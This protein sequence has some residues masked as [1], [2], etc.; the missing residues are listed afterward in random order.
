MP[1]PAPLLTA[2][3]RSSL[4]DL[5]ARLR[6]QRKAL[7]LS[8]TTTAEAAGL[9]RATLHRIEHGEPSVTVGAVTAAARAVG[10]ELV[11]V[12]PRAEQQAQ[13]EQEVPATIRLADHAQ[14]KRV[15]WQLGALTTV[16]PREAL[17]LYERNWRHVDVDAL[18]DGERDLIRRLV[19]AFGGRLLV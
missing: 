7:G 6:A 1:A 5:G 9:S 11:L 17:S 14:L 10:L 15:A 18:D 19:A 3:A 12:D 2:D 4:A 8:A 16:T 13:R